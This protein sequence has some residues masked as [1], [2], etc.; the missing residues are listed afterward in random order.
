MA[1]I[2][3]TAIVDHK[4]SLGKNVSVGP[5]SWIR[6]DVVIGN[7]CRIGSHVVILPHTTL[8]KDCHVCHHVV[9]GEV[10]QDLKFGGEETAVEIGDRTVIREFVTINRATNYN[11]KTVVG[12]DC[13]LMAYVHIAHDC[14]LGDRVILANAVNLAGHVVIEDWAILGGM[15]GIHQFVRIGQHSLIGGGFRATKD[16]PPFIIAAGEPIAFRGLNVTGLKRRG[17]SKEAIA[18]IKR[19]YR[20]IY[21]SQYNVSAALKIIKQD[22]ELT[23][24]VQDIVAFV[25]KSNRG[26]I[27]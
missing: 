25:A 11:R 14:I 19:A 24:P 23:P 2:H 15:V 4:A 6:E 22:G 13:L 16:V 18:A 20:L 10:P 27:K 3:P 26:L 21:R 12:K 17:F 7:N 9:I 1:D 8:G 5:F